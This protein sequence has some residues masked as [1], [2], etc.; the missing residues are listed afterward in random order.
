MF[1]YRG[2]LEEEKRS[3]A[4]KKKSALT[5]GLRPRIVSFSKFAVGINYNMNVE[6]IIYFVSG[7]AAQHI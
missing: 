5:K 4:G 6:L 3:F 7:T 2:K 1:V